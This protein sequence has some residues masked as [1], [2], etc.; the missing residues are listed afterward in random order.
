M[1]LSKKW[2]QQSFHTS[3]RTFLKLAGATVAVMSGTG[4]AVAAPAH[5]RVPR[6]LARRA[7]AGVLDAEFPIEHVG[8]RWPES[9]AG[10]RI[11]F[12]DAAGLFGP[13]HDVEAGCG[14]QAGDT[15]PGGIRSALV[16]AGRASRCELDL[17]PNASAVALNCSDGPPLAVPPTRSTR[18]DL[19]G[20]RLLSRAEWGAD[21]SLRFDE[22]GNELYP[23]TY[24]PVQTVTVHHTAT[25]ND[26]PDPAA[27]VRAIYRFHTID[28]E[29]GD[30]GYHF[31]IDEAGRVYEGRWSG[32]DGTPGFDPAG[33]MVNAAHVGGF[34]AGNVGVALL[35]TFTDRAPT[36]AARG[37]LTRLLAEIVNPRGIDPLGT[38]NYV[39]PI[40]GAT[41]TVPAIPGHRDW[42][43]TECPGDV[44]AG[45]LP[46]IRQDVANAAP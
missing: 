21:E 39:N 5:R 41:R 32:T 7:T 44:L 10:V 37:A 9:G 43:A 24:W 8:V 19:A 20:C 13:W 25:E 36:P 15:A 6:T 34:N 30:I 2:F 28:Q 40:S 17:P 23:P 1:M 11:R 35:G 45:A 27:R 33:N 46:A 16:P 29:F 3:R 18:T 22:D 26:D 12:G 38:V 42:A 4:R 14:V 31:L